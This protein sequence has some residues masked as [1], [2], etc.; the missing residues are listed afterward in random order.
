MAR[1][2][3][4]LTGRK[5]DRWEVIRKSDVRIDNRVAWICKCDCG[6]EKVVIS[7]NLT[8]GLTKSCGCIRIEKQ[9]KHGHNTKERVSSEYNSWHSMKQRCEN[10]NDDRFQDYGGRGIKVCDRWRFFDNF[11]ADMGEKPSPSHS[12]DRID[13]NGDYEPSNCKWATPKEQQRNTRLQ[14]NNS[15]GIRGVTFDKT[16]QKYVAQMYADGRKVLHK[17]FN[18]LTEAKEARKQAELK[19]WG[20]A[21]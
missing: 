20:E 12:I 19:Y 6:E 4:D 10:P 7:T 16:R 3:I 8:R 2:T 5:F 21:K 17:R 11:L 9:I 18:T 13:V 1:K 15:T 14:K